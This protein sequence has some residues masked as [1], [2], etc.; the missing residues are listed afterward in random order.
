[1]EVLATGGDMLLGESQL[2]QHGR[3]TCV[4]APC[5]EGPAGQMVLRLCCLAAFEAFAVPSLHSSR[6]QHAIGVQVVMTLTR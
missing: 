5:M 1:M 4:S 2:R 3:L 6:Q